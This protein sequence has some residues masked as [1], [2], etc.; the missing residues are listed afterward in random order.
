ML[1]RYGVSLVYILINGPIRRVLYCFIQS[2]THVTRVQTSSLIVQ[3]VTIKT[4]GY[5]YSDTFD[6]KQ[7]WTYRAI[8]GTANRTR[9]RLQSKLE[10]TNPPNLVV[11]PFIKDSV[12]GIDKYSSSLNSTH[13]AVKANVVTGQENLAQAVVDVFIRKLT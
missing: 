10:W 11:R 2:Q 1:T 6:V 8:P 13:T 3:F 4:S 5:P 12:C 9:I 7:I